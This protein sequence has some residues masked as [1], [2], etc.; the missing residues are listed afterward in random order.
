[1]R[2]YKHLNNVVKFL[3]GQ[4]KKTGA[5]DDAKMSK[6]IASGIL[7]KALNGEPVIGEVGRYFCAAAYEGTKG[8]ITKATEDIVRDM[9]MQTV[10]ILLDDYMEEVSSKFTHLRP[11]RYSEL[12]DIMD[13]HIKLKFGKMTTDKF[14]K[15]SDDLSVVVKY[16]RGLNRIGLTSDGMFSVVIFKDKIYTTN[17][18][19]D[20]RTLGRIELDGIRPDKLADEIKRI[21]KEGINS[22]KLKHLNYALTESELICRPKNGYL[23][24]VIKMPYGSLVLIPPDVEM[25]LDTLYSRYLGSNT[26]MRKIDVE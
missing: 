5:I 9:N 3:T 24:L 12:M 25:D 13:K 14:G 10:S 20:T 21:Y 19:H 1:M 6:Y 8:N 16:V 26:I 15:V 2:D 22:D 18:F 4:Q 23:E 11:A 7:T 17:N